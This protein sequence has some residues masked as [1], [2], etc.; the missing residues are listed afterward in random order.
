[1]RRPHIGFVENDM[2]R[3][4]GGM[5]IE[6]G[7]E[8]E[9]EAALG[10][11]GA[12]LAQIEDAAFLHAGDRLA[13]Q[14]AGMFGQR[15]IAMRAAEDRHVIAGRVFAVGSEPQAPPHAK[16]IRDDDART[17]R[18]QPL[19]AAHSVVRFARA[20]GAAKEQ[21]II[22][23]SIRYGLLRHHPLLPLGAAWLFSI[24]IRCTVWVFSRL[25]RL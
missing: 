17:F 16:R 5:L 24:R 12:E 25:A 18:Q 13:D 2:Q 15:Q 20:S 11:L 10:C 19:D 9:H 22:K 8:R 1:M 23:T 21:A 7:Q 14:R 3:L 4:A 6:R